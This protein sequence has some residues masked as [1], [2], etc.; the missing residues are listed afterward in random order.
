MG[1]EDLG[2][3]D[4]GVHLRAV[5]D[6]SDRINPDNGLVIRLGPGTAEPRAIYHEATDKIIT[7]GFRQGT[8]GPPVGSQPQYITIDPEGFSGSSLH[9]CGYA[10]S[11][12]AAR[13]FKGQMDEANDQRVFVTQDEGATRTLQEIDPATG[14]LIA[15]NP[16]HAD[17]QNGQHPDNN[18]TLVGRWRNHASSYS[19]EWLIF[20]GIKDGGFG[21][22]P[23]GVG[24]YPKGL[25]LLKI[26]FGTIAVANDVDD[27][28][29]WMDL[30][31]GLI[32]GNLLIPGEAGGVGD[33][34]G[35]AFN[36]QSFEW[37]TTE[38]LVDPENTYNRPKGVLFVFSESNLASPV[39][40]IYVRRVAFN[41]FGVTGGV[42]RT[43]MEIIETSG[44]SFDYAPYD[45]GWPST[46]PNAQLMVRQRTQRIMGLQGDIAQT[47]TAPLVQEIMIREHSTNVV[48]SAVSR[49]ASIGAVRTADTISFESIVYGDLGE[50]VVATTVG[51]ELRRASTRGEV[52]TGLF[53]VSQDTDPVANIPID[54]NDAGDPEGT[55]VVTAYTGATPTVLVEGV[56]YNVVLATGIITWIDDQTGP[57]SILVDYDHREAEVDDSDVQGELLTSTSQSNEAGKVRTRVRYADDDNDVGRLE[58][59]EATI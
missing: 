58:V 13:F 4:I 29:V 49:P 23:G 52:L 12:G 57:D 48:A 28:Y 16:F 55:L 33:F 11:V 25:A 41:P 1:L 2:Y 3:R 7:H 42:I 39:A 54:E 18:P 53:D 14:A 44:L 35:P 8:T 51:W 15:S 47:V 20:D 6:A 37:R 22:V 59:L 56:N 43:H 9:E 32:V 26:L 31:T 46:V 50:R 24:A 21:N 40:T 30:D 27:A 45:T 19:T 38:F 10:N 34:H 5:A 36:G 17:V